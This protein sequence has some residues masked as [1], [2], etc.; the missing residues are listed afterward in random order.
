[1]EQNQ[2]LYDV[3]E[4]ISYWRIRRDEAE[5]MVKS[6]LDE[7]R[8]IQQRERSNPHKT[9]WDMQPMWCHRCGYIAASSLVS[10]EFDPAAVIEVCDECDDKI[11]GREDAMK[12][13]KILQDK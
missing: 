5:K 9:H 12:E 2:E 13:L 10:R 4:L 11:H 7:E 3:R 1:L 8:A 6:L